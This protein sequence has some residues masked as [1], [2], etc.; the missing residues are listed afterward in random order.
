ML[1]T[2]KVSEEAVEVEVESHWVC[3][4][5]VKNWLL[6]WNLQFKERR[7][8]MKVQNVAEVRE[9]CLQRWNRVNT[10]VGKGE[11]SAERKN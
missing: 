11:W 4:E 9:A 8:R 6:L 1:R 2:L 10:S 5:R 7:G 3:N